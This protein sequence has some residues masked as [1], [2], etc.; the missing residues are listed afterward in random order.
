MGHRNWMVS[1]S[2]QRRCDSNN[3]L[4]HHSKLVLE[5][6]K[7]ATPSRKYIQP[8]PRDDPCSIIIL[9]LCN[10]GPASRREISN[11]L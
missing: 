3:E 11:I 10:S 2:E 5:V 4:F 7:L 6:I 8:R 9:I 1:E